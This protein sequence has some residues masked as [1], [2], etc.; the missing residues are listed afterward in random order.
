M[1]FLIVD[2]ETNRQRT[3]RSIL[4]NLGYRAGDVESVTDAAGAI[5]NLKRKRYDCA[6]IASNLPKK[7]GMDLVMEIR[8]TSSWDRVKLVLFCSDPSKDDVVASVQAG[9]NAFLV[10]PCSVGDVEA[11]IKRALGKTRA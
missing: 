11:V 8:R 3:L 9:A 2:N 6:F 1:K 5:Y 10:T 4:S 7:T